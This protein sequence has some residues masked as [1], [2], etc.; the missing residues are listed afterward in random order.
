M[1]RDDLLEA[2]QSNNCQAFLR[3]I[4]EGETSQLTDAYQTIYGGS[5]F[6]S[7]ADH[8]RQKITAGRWT[9]TAAGAFQFLARTWDSLV[10]QYHFPDFSPQCQDEGAVALIAGRKALDD[11][12][13]GRIAQAIEKCNREWASLPGSPY[14]QPTR[15]L[16]Q[17]LDTYQK[18]GGTLAAAGDSP[19]PLPQEVKPMAPIVLPILSVLAQM[20]PQLGAMFGS[21]SE[22]AQRN[23]AA[24][25]LVAQKLVEVTQ[26]VNLQE[27][28]EK[29]QNDPQALAD[30]KA[31]V[32]EV[33]YQL[34][35]VGGGITKARES[36]YDPN[37]VPL[38]KNPAFIVAG[39][40]TPLIYMV[41]VEILFN[42]SKQTWSDDIKMMFVTA[43]VSGLL[44]SITGFF[45]GSSLGSQKK[46]A[47]VQR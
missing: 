42:P 15:T 39:L 12:L 27:A 47:M 9:S 18:F 45:M 13:S 23:V 19:A 36:A 41:A 29:I 14:G 16:A 6:E 10:K 38:Y 4:R 2:L 11:V 44:G 35:E 43:V 25:T 5:R 30:A 26:S 40:L 7:F 46:D 33:V 20:I 28:A 31:A 3:V 32:Q 8:P 17:A 1:T 22:V 37:Q 34:S 21:G 24:G